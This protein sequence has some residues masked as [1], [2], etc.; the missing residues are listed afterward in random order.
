MVQ[1]L[2]QV[3]VQ[4]HG[5]IKGNIQIQCDQIILK[6]KGMLCLKKDMLLQ[7][8]EGICDLPTVHIYSSV[9]VKE[10]NSWISEKRAKFN[11]HDLD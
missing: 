8:R 11:I 4:Q 2:I 7:W 1:I 3:P 5:Q 9:E 6:Q 10:L